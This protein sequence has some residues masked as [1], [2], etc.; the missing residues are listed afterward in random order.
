[1]K[2]KETRRRGGWGVDCFFYKIWG[3]HLVFIRGVGL[4]KRKQTVSGLIAGGKK[5]WG[6]V[7]F[8]G[9]KKLHD[10]HGCIRGGGGQEGRTSTGEICLEEKKN[11]SKVLLIEVLR[12]F[13]EGGERG[14]P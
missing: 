9:G 6:V 11:G 2:G 3:G 10:R 12:G 14:W 13:L 8:R 7:D 5:K 1:V 4:A